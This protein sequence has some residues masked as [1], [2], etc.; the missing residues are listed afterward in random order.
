MF[1][2]LFFAV[3]PPKKQ[4]LLREFIKSDVS[5]A[6][7]QDDVILAHWRTFNQSSRQIDH[8]C[9][10]MQSNSALSSRSLNPCDSLSSGYKTF[11]IKNNFFI[12]SN[13]YEQIA[14]INRNNRKTRQL[15]HLIPDI[16][17]LPTHFSQM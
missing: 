5:I 6:D 16:L 1:I 17:C 8:I 4:K 3:P 2:N 12:T 14:A 15:Q 9:D 13:F 10:V 7:K 11:H